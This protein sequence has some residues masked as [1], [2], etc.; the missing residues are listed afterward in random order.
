[1]DSGP[2]QVMHLS[3]YEQKYD[4]IGPRIIRR[5]VLNADCTPA[6]VMV[7][8]VQVLVARVVKA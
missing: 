2:L 8:E 5:Q 1:M 3:R 4:G 7:V 6:E